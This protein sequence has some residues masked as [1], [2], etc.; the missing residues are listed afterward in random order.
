M[1][2]NPSRVGTLLGWA[3]SKQL[4]DAIVLEAR[5]IKEDIESMPAHER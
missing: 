5:D 4:F 2:V 1:V 3:P